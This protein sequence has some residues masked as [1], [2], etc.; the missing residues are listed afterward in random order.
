MTRYKHT[1]VGWLLTILGVSAL[2][3]VTALTVAVHAPPGMTVVAVVAA[4]I[5]FLFCR[6]TTEVTDD[7]FLFRFSLGVVRRTIARSEIA[8]CR[9]VTNAWYWGLGIHLTP[10]GWLYNVAGAKAVELDLRN[11]RHLRVGTDEPE[12]LC[13]ALN[14]NWQMNDRAQPTA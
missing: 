2:V 1:Q 3:G 5:M 8:A 7:A 10:R 11:G 12:Q 9:P 4:S 13:A 14:S 6:L